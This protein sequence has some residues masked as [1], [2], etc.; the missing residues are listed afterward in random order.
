[1]STLAAGVLLAWIARAADTETQAQVQTTLRGVLVAP[2]TNAAAGV[3]AVLES[4]RQTRKPCPLRAADAEVAVQ[5]R[6]L[7]ATGAVVQVTGT[8]G[9]EAFTVRAIR[10]DGRA[11]QAKADEEPQGASIIP[12]IRWIA[13][14]A[15][16][17]R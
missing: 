10:A 16:A 14:P 12:P 5:I 3:V 13:V 7:T 15:D 2:G 17:G 8:P 6:E 11:R 4:S 9:A 1:M